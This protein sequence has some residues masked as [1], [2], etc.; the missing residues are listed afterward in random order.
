MP[1]QALAPQVHF[2]PTAQIASREDVQSRLEA[3]YRPTAPSPTPAPLPAV[4]EDEDSAP[5][6]QYAQEL[7][8][9]LSIATT[10]APKL[11][12]GGSVADSLKK[13]R[14]DRKNEDR[15][16]GVFG[17]LWRLSAVGV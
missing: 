3:Y 5:L 16:R 17:S 13:R 1:P 6:P 11:D 8:E 10:E 12:V 15:R 9:G 14:P 7:L 4:T 2:V